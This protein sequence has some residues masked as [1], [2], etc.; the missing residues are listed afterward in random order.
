M[1]SELKIN[2][3]TSDLKIKEEFDKRLDRNYDPSFEF[4]AVLGEYLL[5]L[6]WLDREWVEKNINNIFPKDN[7]KHWSIAFTGYLHSDSRVWEEIYLLLK[8]NGHYEKAINIPFDDED[9]NKYCIQQIVIGFLEDLEKLDDVNSLI[10]NLLN[11]KNKDFLSQI[12]YFLC[13]TDIV[14]KNKE[15]VKP[16]WKAIVDILIQKQDDPEYQKI[17]AQLLMFISLIDEIDDNVLEWLMFSA[18]YATVEH[19]LDQF[20]RLLSEHTVKTP[21]YVTQILIEV[22]KNGVPKH[23]Y[24]GEEIK[25]IVE[26]LYLHGEKELA[27]RICNICLERW[28]DFLKDIYNKYNE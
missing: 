12:I 13:D 14:G 23:Y 19:N 24:Q 10:S 8:E 28:G 6:F 17:I 3:M 4:S 16:L 2:K 20:L 15:K 11:S 1:I 5:S 18:K 7:E 21:K 26:K 22:V 27:I 9:S 25:E